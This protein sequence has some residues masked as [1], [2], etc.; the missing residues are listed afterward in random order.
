VVPRRVA[1]S[2]I[3]VLGAVLLAGCTPGGHFE[4]AG[5][6]TAPNYDTTI[7]TV[8]VPIFQNQTYIQGLEF[9]L[10][11]EVVR[12]IE[13]KTPYKVV[14]SESADTELI[15]NIT[16][17]TKYLLN[18]NQLNE[19]REA[20]TVLVVELVWRDLRTGEIL[21]RPQR[22]PG[23]PPENIRIATEAQPLAPA[24]VQPNGATPPG[25]PPPGV[26]LL[27]PFVVVSTVGNF[28]PELGE[29]VTTSLQKNIKRMGTQIVSM[30]ECP[31]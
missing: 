24:G 13:Q 11:R 17:V 18:R 6:T 12:Q 28:V 7:R 4:V 27:Q 16:T 10:T 23:A 2:F 26:P 5:Y 9:D 1:F 30:M 21:S 8:R 14:Q 3:L 25:L 29:S 22:G 20:E 31:W 15:G 19:V